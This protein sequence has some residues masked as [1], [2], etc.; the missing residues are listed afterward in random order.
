MDIQI[1]IKDDRLYTD[2]ASVVDREDF[3]KEVKRIRSAL[4]IEIP[5]SDDQLSKIPTDDEIKKMDV[6]V[7]KSRKRLYLPITYSGVITAVVY[8]NEVSDSDYSPAYLDCKRDVFYYMDEATTPDD[9]YYIVLSPGAREKD[10]LKAYRKYTSQLGNF[11]GVPKYEYIHKIW[12]VSK[13]QP[14]IRKHREWYLAYKSGKKPSQIAKNE[15]NF[16]ESTIRKGIEKYES[17]IWKTPT[18]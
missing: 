17:F 18:L 10:V 3:L 14:S 15:V 6:E 5:L 13:E 4:D 8:R 11:K 9:T 1:N 7:E 12:D 2:V 16:H